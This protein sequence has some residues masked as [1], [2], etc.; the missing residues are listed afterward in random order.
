VLPL[1]ETG[2]Y[3][4]QVRDADEVLA[5]AESL[6][7]DAAFWGEMAILALPVQIQERVRA[8]K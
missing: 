1:P 5:E 2:F 4:Q 6:R 7:Q 8:K 3:E